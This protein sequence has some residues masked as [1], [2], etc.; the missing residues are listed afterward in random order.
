MS[1]KTY[2]W[3][4]HERGLRATER[5]ERRYRFA[6]DHGW[7][8]SYLLFCGE[9]PC[10]FLGGYQWKGRYYIDEIGFDPAFTKHS[11]GTVLQMMAI[12]D[13]FDYRQTGTDR[14]RLI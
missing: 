10:A 7:F 2:Q 11:P 8:R 13:M 6:A 9:T 1:Q 14:F 4:L 3:N 12:Q 5:F